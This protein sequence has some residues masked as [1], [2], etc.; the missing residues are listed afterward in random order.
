MNQSNK[1]E[2]EDTGVDID[3][4]GYRSYLLRC[5]REPGPAGTVTWRFRLQSVNGD[6]QRGFRDLRTVFEHV[7]RLLFTELDGPDRGDGPAEE[8]PV[9]Q[10]DER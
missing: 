8:P 3:T 10:G 9:K 1:K 2:S 4:D 5:W 7:A 6:E